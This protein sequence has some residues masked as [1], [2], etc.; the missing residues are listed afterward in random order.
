M[1]S[2]KRV[3]S[4]TSSFSKRIKL[5]HIDV[6]IESET[7]ELAPNVFTKIDPEDI[8]NCKGPPK[9]SEIYNQ[10]VWMRSKFLAPVDTQGCERMPNAINA[11]IK[12]RN[13]KVYR[14]QLLISLMLSSQTKDEVN[15]QAMKN[16]HEGLLKVHPDGLCIESLSKLSEAEI[17]SYIKKV[18]FHNRKAQYIKKTCSILM[19]NFG[20]DIPKTIE[21]IVALPGVGPKMGFLLLQSAWGI[22]A[23]VG[24]DVHLHRLA[25]M[26][27]WVSQKANT[28]EKARLE[29]QEW[30]PKNYWADINPL[31]VGFGQVICVPRAANCDI[32]SLAR[33]GLCKNANKKLLRTPLSEE[34]INKLSKQRADLSQLLKEFI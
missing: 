19:E 22:N 30:L 6:E 11:N 24:V 23:G 17:D 28:P 27:G 9:W 13:P 21:E 15:Y 4:N 26:W 31:V 34:R 2:T 16:L 1:K 5:E 25:L 3:I 7:T 8:H 29:L 33:D 12:L 14:F 18:G 10:L 32:C 20:G